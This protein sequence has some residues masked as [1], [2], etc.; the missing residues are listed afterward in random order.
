MPW[1]PGVH[2]IKIGLFHAVLVKILREKPWKSGK[3]KKYSP[4]C[5]WDMFTSLSYRTAVTT[6]CIAVYLLS[7]LCVQQ[8]CVH[9]EWIFDSF[10]NICG[11][12]A[13]QNLSSCDSC[14]C[15]SILPVHRSVPFDD[16]RTFFSQTRDSN[17]QPTM[18][19]NPS[20]AL[21]L[22]L[23]GDLE[24]NPGPNHDS[25]NQ[26]KTRKD[27]GPSVEELINRLGEKL[28]SRMDV[29]ADEVRS[30]SSSFSSVSAQIDA[31]G[32]QME[33]RERGSCLQ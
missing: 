2:R 26:D 22:F 3:P 25:H 28:G 23:C 1:C 24:L 8:L 20:S 9:S 11:G 5:K 16:F 29:F 12:Y 13:K 6:F 21:F 19:A 4:Y 27:S 32:R 31:L 14:V 33:E 15:G 7:A 17:D 30:L 18:Y 10:V